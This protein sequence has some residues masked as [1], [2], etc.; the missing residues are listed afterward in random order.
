MSS[1]VLVLLAAALAHLVI[2]P[3]SKVE[4]SFNMQAS[5]LMSPKWCGANPYTGFARP[6][7]LSRKHHFGSL[8][9]R[10]V[11]EEGG[12]VS[13]LKSSNTDFILI[14]SPY[15]QYDHFEFPGVVPR[16]F[17][18]P[19]V[20]AALS[21]PISFIALSLDFPI[22]TLQYI[23]RVCVWIISFTVYTDLMM[24]DRYYLSLS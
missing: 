22:I 23:G 24:L 20:I 10:E 9:L 21:S 4:E 2:S 6:Y 16:T 14:I 3:Y 7:V 11:E 1:I 19:I 12:M 17:I 13:F 8:L 15:S 18:G 5:C